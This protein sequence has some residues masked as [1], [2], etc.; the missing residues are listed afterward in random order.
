MTTAVFMVVAVLLVAIALAWVLWPLLRRR[1]AAGDVDRIGTNLALL[2]DQ[3]AELEAERARGAL[4]EAQYVEAKNELERR[5][6]EETPVPAPAPRPMRGVRASA[7]AI[8]IVLP[9][10]AAL[11]YLRLGEPGGFDPQ[12]QAPD[13]HAAMT[14]ETIER[15]VAQLAQRLEREPDNLEGWVMLAR[16]YYHMGRFADAARAY[17]R[18]AQLL[19]TDADVLADWADTLAMA[20][21]RTLA[22]RPNEIVLRA[23]ELNPNHWKAL[24]L[25]GTAAFDRQDYRAAVEYWERLRGVLPPD[26]EVAKNIEGGIAEAR[27][28]AGLPGAGG[29][30]ALAQQGAASKGAAARGATAGGAAAGG[31]QADDKAAQGAVPKSNAAQLATG[32]GAGIAGTVKLSPS[33][34]ARAAPDDLVFVFA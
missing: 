18:V 22:G 9:I 33:L 31:T 24:A 17:E 19:P 7:F 28:R 10:A 20:N 14:P 27:A 11:L 16:S 1:A 29:R 5:A 6:L 13:Q 32:P 26:N 34:A 12:A 3:L 23:L 21:N 25:A 30:D 15:L 2:K 8:A 4:A